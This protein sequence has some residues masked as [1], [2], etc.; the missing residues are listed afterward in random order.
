M[1]GE[2]AGRIGYHPGTARRELA[3]YL[4][5]RSRAASSPQS[6]TDMQAVA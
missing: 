3:R 5:E 1:A 4:A 2:I 6:E